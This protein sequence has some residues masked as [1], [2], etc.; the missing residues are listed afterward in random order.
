MMDTLDD[1]LSW[2]TVSLVLGGSL[3]MLSVIAVLY[4][5]KRHRHAKLRAAEDR[6]NFIYLYM[7]I[8][9]LSAT[10]LWFLFFRNPFKTGSVKH[11]AFFTKYILGGGFGLGDTGGGLLSFL[12]L[13]GSGLGRK[14][15]WGFLCGMAS[16]I[17]FRNRYTTNNFIKAIVL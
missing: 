11:T 7:P 2:R 5:Y 16:I 13:S 3:A 14:F 15:L 17:A 10:A 9:M 8:L 12:G 4:L 6:R 1:L